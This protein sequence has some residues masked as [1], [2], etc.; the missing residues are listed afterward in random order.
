LDEDR[1]LL[2]D[3]DPLYD[4]LLPEL[5]DEPRLLVLSDDLLVERCTFGLVA[6][7]WLFPEDPLYDSL[8]PELVADLLL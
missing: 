5:T 8:A 3:E 2:P 6:D 4:R 1:E 7:L